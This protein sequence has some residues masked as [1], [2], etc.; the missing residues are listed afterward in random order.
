M[1]SSLLTGPP[2]GSLGSCSVALAQLKCIIRLM[3]CVAA[4]CSIMVG[5]LS[6]G[7]FKTFCRLMADGVK[8]SCSDEEPTSCHSKGCTPCRGEGWTPCPG[9]GRASTLHLRPGTG[10][11]KMVV[12][13]IIWLTTQRDWPLNFEPTLAVSICAISGLSGS[14]SHPPLSYNA[15]V[16]TSCILPWW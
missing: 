8:T 4:L 15:T 3:M 6:T 10:F 5:V 14:G 11:C 12:T 16:F 2:V 7:A 9:E 13:N 1:W